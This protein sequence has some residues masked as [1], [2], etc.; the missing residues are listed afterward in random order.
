ME[1]REALRSRTVLEFPTIHV[2]SEPPHELPEGVVTE[3]EFVE[4]EKDEVQRLRAA[5]SE[6]ETYD[7]QAQQDRQAVPGLKQPLNADEVLKVLK[8][9]MGRD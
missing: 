6:L 1:L 9:D 8:S 4:K 7:N 5:A 2:R 3:D